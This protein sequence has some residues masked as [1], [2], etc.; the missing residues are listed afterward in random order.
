MVDL[1]GDLLFLNDAFASM[2]GYRSD[3]LIGESL[4]V[5]HNEDQ[6]PS[7]IEAN[8]RIFQKGGFSG[9]IW[10]TRKD[11]STF[12]GLMHNS[13]LTDEAG[14]PSGLIGTLRDI[15]DIKRTEEQLRQ[16]HEKLEAYSSSLEAKVRERTKELEA[17]QVQLKKYSEGLEKTNEALKLVIQSIEEQKKDFERKITHNLNLAVKPILEQL[18]TQDFPEA[19][20]FLLRSLEFNLDN[21]FSSFGINLMKEGSNLTP[22]EIR[23]CEMIRAGLSSK[24]MAKTLA[25]SPQTVLV[26]RKNIRKKLGLANSKRNLASFLKANL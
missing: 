6:M 26:H 7:V 23:I 20:G 25:I 17:S 11:G 21:V 18:K 14:E 4:S 3:E 1:N 5:F 15:S 19:V 9:E 8:E 12:P 16:S 22:R 24:E 2:H 10:H 13:V